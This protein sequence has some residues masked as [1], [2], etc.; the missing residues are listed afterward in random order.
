MKEKGVI[1]RQDVDS[2]V[3]VTIETSIFK[4]TD[5]LGNQQPDAA[6]RIYRQLIQDNEPVQRI[7]YMMIRQFRLL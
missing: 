7:F 4:L 6:Y 2:I 5:H 3:S 1:T